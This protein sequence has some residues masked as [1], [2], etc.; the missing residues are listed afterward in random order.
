[1]C[2]Q[3]FE[4]FAIFVENKKS[5]SFYR[6]YRAYCDDSFYFSRSMLIYVFIHCLYF[7]I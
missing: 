6:V 2:K 1:M 7:T 5:M 3:T 4:I